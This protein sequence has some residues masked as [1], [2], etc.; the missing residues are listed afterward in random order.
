VTESTNAVVTGGRKSRVRGLLPKL[1]LSL[2]TLIVLGVV[3]EIGARILL[4]REIFSFGPVYTTDDIAG[5]R[6]KPNLSEYAFGAQLDTNSFGRRGREWSKEKPPRVWRIVL[7]GDSIAF[8]FGVRFAE[9][10]GEVLARLVTERTSVPCEV[11]NFSAPGYNSVQELA[12]L[13]EQALGFH[14]DLVL[15][16][17]TAND[18]DPRLWTDAGGFLHWGEPGWVNTRIESAQVPR[19]DRWGMLRH[20]A[21]LTWVKMLWSRY[22]ARELSERPKEPEQWMGPLEPGPVPPHLVTTVLEPLLAMQKLCLEHEVPM[23]LATFAAQRGYR[24]LVREW[25]G[26]TAGPSLELLTLF[27][28]VKSW[29]QMVERFGLGWDPHPNAEANERWAHALL[30]LFVKHG[31][32][33][34]K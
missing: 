22:K 13:E 18:H 31:F 27:P 5:Y 8:G 24:C 2:A 3:L 32:L 9:T 33:P 1:A 11:L 23:V 34:A 16:L 29:D 6:L 28:E 17:T 15:V 30:E 4:P 20:S 26:R 14:P 7:I 25:T 21:L 12:V 19:Q 10:V